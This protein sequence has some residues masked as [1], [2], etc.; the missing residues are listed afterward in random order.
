VAYNGILVPLGWFPHRILCPLVG[1]SEY[2][3]KKSDHFLQLLKSVDTYS[4]ALILSVFSLMYQSIKSC[5]SSVINSI[6]V[7]QFVS[8]DEEDIVEL[9]EFF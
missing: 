9:M 2:F 1:N 7:E 8:Q 3:V 4:L 6:M 5:K